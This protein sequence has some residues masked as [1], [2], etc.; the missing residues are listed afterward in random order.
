MYRKSQYKYFVKI[1]SIV[2]VYELQQ[3]QKIVQRNR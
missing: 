3:Y 1:S 2:I